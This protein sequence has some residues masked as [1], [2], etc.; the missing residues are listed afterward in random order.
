MRALVVFLLASTGCGSYVGTA[1]DFSPSILS[2]EHG[3]IAVREVSWLAQRDD[4]DCGAAA[5]G[6]VVAHWTGAEPQVVA[7]AVRP[8]GKSGI[9]ADRLRAEARRHGLAAFL[10]HG[11][12]ADLEHELRRGRPVLVGLVKPHRNDALAHYEVVVAYHPERRV[13]VTLDPATGWRQ[14]SLRGFLAE[15]KPPGYLALIVAPRDHAQI[16]KIPGGGGKV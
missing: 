8:A 14:N 16:W 13:V 10:V 2:R 6:M 11:R 4:A 9:R 15:W 1:R 5:I 12:I 7:D 3:W